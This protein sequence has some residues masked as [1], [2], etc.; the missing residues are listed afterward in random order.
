MQQVIRSSQEP[1]EL[2]AEGEL[3]FLQLGEGRFCFANFD[4]EQDKYLLGEPFSCDNWEDLA[5]FI[6]GVARKVHRIDGVREILSDVFPEELRNFLNWL[7][8][9]QAHPSDNMMATK[10]RFDQV[11]SNP[12]GEAL[13]TNKL[14]GLNFL[15]DGGKVKIVPDLDPSKNIVLNGHLVLGV[16]VFVLSHPST[17][18]IAPNNHGGFLRG[19][20]DKLLEDPKNLQLLALDLKESPSPPEAADESEVVTLGSMV[21]PTPHS[22]W[23][24]RARKGLDS[25]MSEHGLVG[26][27]PE[28]IVEE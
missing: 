4:F 24:D 7:P 8:E 22:T 17:L 18:D 5:R 26:P 1:K 23:L 14:G 10:S 13:A 11:Q 20:L 25:A 28:I 21:L 16:I 19:Y 15:E 27:M 6:N 2:F 3:A 12:H 9:W